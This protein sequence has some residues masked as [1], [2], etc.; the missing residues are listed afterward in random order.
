LDVPLPKGTPDSDPKRLPIS[1]RDLH[2]RENHTYR[3]W[4]SKLGRPRSAESS[5]QDEQHQPETE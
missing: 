2:I 5:H 3:A 4:L 1:Q